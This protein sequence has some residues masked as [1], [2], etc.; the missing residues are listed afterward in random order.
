MEDAHQISH[1]SSSGWCGSCSSVSDDEE[2]SG[3]DEAEQHV[4]L[5][6][7]ANAGRRHA[8]HANTFTR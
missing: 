6:Q 3:D 8:E 2:F 1:A 5:E 4:L 7:Q